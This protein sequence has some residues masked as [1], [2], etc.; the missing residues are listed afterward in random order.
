MLACLQTYAA[1]YVEASLQTFNT[2]PLARTCAKASQAAPQLLS[3]ACSDCTPCAAACPSPAASDTG[4]GIAVVSIRCTRSGRTFPE[5]FAVNLAATAGTTDCN[6]AVTASATVQTRCCSSGPAYARNSKSATCIG[7][8]GVAGYVNSFT[9]AASTSSFPM[10]ISSNCS[11]QGAAGGSATIGCAN[12]GTTMS[13]ITVGSK[14][15]NGVPG[16]VAGDVSTYF[17]VGCKNNA[18]QGCAAAP[19]GFG[20]GACTSSITGAVPQSCSGSITAGAAQ[21]VTLSCPCAGVQWKIASVGQPGFVFT[22]GRA[23]GQ[24][25]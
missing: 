17:W 16:D 25:P 6:T 1:Y 8:S 9:G 7:C 24:C 12:L 3:D 4:T 22:A 13:K 18:S 11:A 5:T 14:S 15:Y 20:A 21:T 10:V 23:N 2:R 19:S